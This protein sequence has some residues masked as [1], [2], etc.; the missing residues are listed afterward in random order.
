[1]I[2]WVIAGLCGAAIGLYSRGR[3]N[4]A[5][6]YHEPRA[7]RLLPAETRK[8]Y[9]GDC[10]KT[11]GYHSV[12]CVARQVERRAL[13]ADSFT[14]CTSCGFTERECR[15]SGTHREVRWAMA[16]CCAA[17]YHKPPPTSLPG[18]GT[19]RLG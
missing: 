13:T 10:G 6:Q 11:D 14:R 3:W 12:E 9:C 5:S 4:R 18:P 8:A 17:C 16:V 19:P 2:A 1:M 15:R 7:V